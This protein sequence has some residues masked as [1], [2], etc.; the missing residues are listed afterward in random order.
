MSLLTIEDILSEF[1][2]IQGL[3]LV[4]HSHEKECLLKG[5]ARLSVMAKMADVVQSEQDTKDAF[6][7]DS[8]DGSLDEEA[9]R[10]ENLARL[11]L[12]RAVSIE[13]ADIKRASLLFKRFAKAWLW[14][15]GSEL[16]GCIRALKG[17]KKS[18]MVLF[19]SG[20]YAFLVYRDE[21]V[22][23]LISKDYAVTLDKVTTSWKKL[24]K[25]GVS[26]PQNRF[27]LGKQ[28]GERP[29][30]FK[31]RCE[32][33]H[34]GL[35]EE[36]GHDEVGQHVLHKVSMVLVAHGIHKHSGIRT[37]NDED[38]SKWLGKSQLAIEFLKPVRDRLARLQDT[39]QAE[40]RMRLE[41]LR[42][43]R[44]KEVVSAT[45]TTVLVNEDRIELL[46]DL[47]KETAICLDVKDIF[48]AKP[49]KVLDM[50]AKVQKQGQD[51]TDLLNIRSELCFMS[52]KQA[53]L[54]SAVSARNCWTRFAQSILKY[55]IN[56]ILPPRTEQHVVWY[57]SKFRNAGTAAN[58]L[59]VLRWFCR[60]RAL[61]LHWDTERLKLLLKG[62]KKLTMS[63]MASALHSELA[64]LSDPLVYTVAR[65]AKA[66]KMVQFHAIHLISWFFLGRV[67]SEVLPSKWVTLRISLRSCQL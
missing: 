30:G 24:V 21:S 12:N 41:A 38:M 52:T 1:G 26:V 6:L 61:S 16:E 7:S 29:H 36:T 3:L 37:L 23:M 42:N 53:S 45:E 59:G 51:P 60:I 50:L 57:V 2:C 43:C 55:D 62:L 39:A 20:L 14:N 17:I 18:K 67:Q 28:F 15:Q 4:Y 32:E 25:E 58:Y 27:P 22:T 31:R 33:I 44:P 9:V 63:Q 65:L 34:E 47:I 35:L 10:I 66:R 11:E 8:S 56:E 48:N 54:G 40:H 46:H 64:L 19:S 13:E 5:K 49:S